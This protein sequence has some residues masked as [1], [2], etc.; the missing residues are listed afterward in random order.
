MPVKVLITVPKRHFR[1]AVE[2]NLI[3]RRIREA[4]RKNKEPL[5]TVMRESGRYAEI[6]LVWTGSTIREWEHV[7]NSVKEVIRRV[8]AMKY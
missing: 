6:A 5:I 1:K 3:R 2:R 7:E 4:W 8:A